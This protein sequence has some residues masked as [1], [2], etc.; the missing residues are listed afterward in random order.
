[1]RA[2]LP[3]PGELLEWDTRFFGF[4]VARLRAD[5]LTPAGVRD[6]LAWCREQRVRC[7]YF[8]A[9][10]DDA[11]TVRLAEDHGFR[12]VD[13]RVTLELPDRAAFRPAPPVPGVRVR[14]A[15]PADLPELRRL[16]RESFR[17]S[18]FYYD[19][20]FPRALC[21]GLYDHWLTADVHGGVALALVAELQGRPAGFLTGRPARPAAAIGLLGVDSARQGRGVG[22]LLLARAVDRLCSRP[23]GRLRVVTQGRN[24]DAQRFYQLAGFVSCSVELW[25]HWWA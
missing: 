7:L 19:G 18:R 13:L 10:A 14:D 6:T 5:T 8:L 24:I 12:L 16:A 17:L 2:P 1:M 25:Y 21:D 3:A 4:P 11:Q 20:R 22:S 15:V 9:R 23:P